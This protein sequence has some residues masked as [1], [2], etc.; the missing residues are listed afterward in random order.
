MVS[1]RLVC[2]IEEL[3][4]EDNDLVGK[5]CANLGELSRIGVR[6]PPGFAVTVHGWKR[7]VER[8]GIA[9]AMNRVFDR[10]QGELHLPARGQEV[11]QTVRDLIEAEKIPDEIADPIRSSYARLC[12][13]AGLSEVSV[14]VRSA[15]TISMPG[16]METYLNI[17][18]E[19]DVLQKILQVW[20]SAYTYRA[21]LYRH[22][23]SMSPEYAP[24][25][26][27]VLQLV[28]ARSAG[29]LMTANPTSGNTEEMV[30]E[31][32]WGLGESVVSGV[33]N[34]DRF[35]VAKNDL[36]VTRVINSKLK[37]VVPAGEGTEIADVPIE[38]QRAPSLTD[39][40]VKQLAREA[41]RIEKHFG[42]ATDVEWAYS[43]ERAFPENLYFLQARPM[44]SLPKYKD[45]IAKALDMMIGR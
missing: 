41:L 8:T 40:E 37:K 35:N 6:V 18:S 16:A 19:A 22:N 1:S 30:V 45:G 7:F 27:A 26:V 4:K 21:I 14:A 32:N 20:G 2:W 9:D 15:G 3:G 13:K 11:S 31:S 39:D 23:H 17:R 10:A 44:K 36:T 42:E 12:E 34:P 28:D 25:G 5:K 43:A 24:M 38:L 33:I 29:V